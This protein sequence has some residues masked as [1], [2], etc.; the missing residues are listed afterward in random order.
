MLL[1]EHPNTDIACMAS[2]L[3][4]EI[5]EERDLDHQED[6]FAKILDQNDFLA[7]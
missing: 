6:L 4:Q 1:V 7:I 5:G 3:I 2:K